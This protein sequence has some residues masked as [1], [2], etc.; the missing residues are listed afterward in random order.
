M[1]IEQSN[2]PRMSVAV[3]AERLG[4]ETGHLEEPSDYVLMGAGG[5]AD[6]RV[7]PIPMHRSADF[8]DRADR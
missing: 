1:D 8:L 2:E 6:G 3:M 7:A 4:P 5:G